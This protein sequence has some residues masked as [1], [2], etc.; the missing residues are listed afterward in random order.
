VEITRGPPALAGAL[1]KIDGDPRPVAVTNRATA[2]LYIAN[3][4]KRTSG[5]GLFD[6]HPPIEKRIAIL[7]SMASIDLAAGRSPDE[8]ATTARVA[9]A[10]S[11]Q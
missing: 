9:S 11:P 7:R 8:R 4:I 10:P 5:D 6:T 3:S 2:H 1:E